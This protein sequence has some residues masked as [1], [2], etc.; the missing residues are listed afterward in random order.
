MENVCAWDN[1]LL[2]VL[3][4]RKSFEELNFLGYDELL[5]FFMVLCKLDFLLTS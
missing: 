1:V 5:D 3:V 4:Y 2:D